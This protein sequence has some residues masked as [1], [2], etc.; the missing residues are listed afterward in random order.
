MTGYGETIKNGKSGDLYIKINVKVLTKIS[1]RAKE[2]LE[3]L[4]KEG[5]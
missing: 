1:K 3:E 4:K 2:L 5:I